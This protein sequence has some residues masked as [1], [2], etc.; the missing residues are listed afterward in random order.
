MLAGRGD[1]RS[2][3]ARRAGLGQRDL[4]EAE[5]ELPR[6]VVGAD[7]VER[8][9]LEHPDARAVALGGR[10]V[11]ATEEMV[12]DEL[13]GPREAVAMERAIDDGSHPPAGDRVLAQLEEPGRHRAQVPASSAPSAVA[14][15]GANMRRGALDRLGR[16]PGVRVAQLGGDRGRP[17]V[18]HPARVDEPEILEV[19]G[20][21]EGDP[22][23]AH[24]AFDAQAE[25]PDLARIRA[26]R[27]AP[28]AGLAFAPAGLD[29]E[30]GA[31]RGEGRLERA[32]ERPDHQP[33]RPRARIG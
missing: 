12:V 26:A 8:E 22:V 2:P 14:S 28:A 16:R 29:A 23:V 25:C 7:D 9:V 20:H 6:V 19:D 13:G 33:A 32:D 11:G 17:H 30:L 27:V 4:G 21:V 5:V 3:A 31:G 24:A 15:A 18:G 1:D 10:A